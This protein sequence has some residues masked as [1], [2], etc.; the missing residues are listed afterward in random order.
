MQIDAAKFKPLTEA[1][2]LRRRTN[3]MC[4]YY[5]N[6]RHITHHCL[7]KLVKLQVQAV[8][9]PQELENKNIQSQ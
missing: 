9:T 8:E 4:L 5:G 1:E 3:N 7:Q 2:K 6:P